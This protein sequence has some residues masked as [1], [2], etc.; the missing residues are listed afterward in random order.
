M[1]NN[2]PK[3]KTENINLHRF[4][5]VHSEGEVEYCDS[6]LVKN[7]V[8]ENWSEDIE[9]E[10][11]DFLTRYDLDKIHNKHIDIFETGL[12]NSLTTII[13]I[14]VD[15]CNDYRLNIQTN[16]Y[17][18]MFYLEHPQDIDFVIELKIEGIYS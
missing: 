9:S 8:N 17:G 5:V 18:T 1:K 15:S 10:Y 14:K 4:K 7:A 16:G 12:F 3:Y 13:E 6:N 11:V 2:L